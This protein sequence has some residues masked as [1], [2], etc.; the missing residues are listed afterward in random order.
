VTVGDVAGAPTPLEEQREFLL[1]SLED[2]EQERAAGD[3]D[4]ADYLALK[5]D[6]TARAAAILRAIDVAHAPA[7]AGTPRPWRRTVAVAAAVLAFAVGAGVLVAQSAGRRDPNDTATGAVD[8]SVTELLNE[9]GRRTAEGDLEVALDRY[10]EVLDREP[11]NAEAMTYR[12]W[13]LT[14]SGEPEAGLTGLLEAA[15]THPDYPDVHAFL[16]I[17]FF[18]NGLVEQAGRELDRLD[19]LDPPPAIRQLT[20][21]LR[22]QVD[23]A[24]TEPTPTTATT[25]A[26]G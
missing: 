17:L 14:L 20:E 25:T 8:R 11:T 4:E 23:A 13:L 10:E 2:L 12:A 16:A 5:D 1:R 6:Y 24:L 19:A 7:S 21:G 9:A 18:R 3:V 26:A 15:T 22:A